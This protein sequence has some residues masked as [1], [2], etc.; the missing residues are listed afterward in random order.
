MVEWLAGNRIRGTSTERTTTSGFNP[1]STVQAGW[2]QVGKFTLGSS[3]NQIDVSSIPDKRYYMVLTHIKDSGQAN[4]RYRFGSSGSIDTSTNYAFRRWDNGS[5]STSH[6]TSSLLMTGDQA[7]DDKFHVMFASNLLNRN[8]LFEILYAERGDNLSA[9]NV[10]RASKGIGKWTETDPLDT[11]R[12]YDSVGTGSYNSGS[13]VVVLGWDPDDTHTDNFW[14]ELANV[15]LS[16][17]A[18][19]NLSSGTISAK[20]Y[21]WVQYYAQTSAS[22][23]I[24]FT[25]NNSTSGYCDMRQINDSAYTGKINQDNWEDEG[26]LSA[27]RGIFVNMFIINNANSVKLGIVNSVRDMGGSAGTQPQKRHWVGKW[28]E[29]TDQIT[30]IDLTAS[31]GNLQ[32]V[33]ELRVWGADPV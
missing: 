11:L 27:N 15:N 4:V 33:S 10:P 9:A 18:N 8:K 6:T 30:E 28:T 24:K 2:K 31:S 25:F 5:A 32:S 29:T 23:D 17:G 7:D 1:I 16:G 12:V 3:A 22:A 21:L 14:Q 13:E 26:G 19:S 20:K